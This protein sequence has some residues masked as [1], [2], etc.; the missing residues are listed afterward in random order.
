MTYWLLG[1]G[2][3]IILSG[4]VGAICSLNIQEYNIGVSN[5]TDPPMMEIN[6]QEQFEKINNENIEEYKTEKYENEISSVEQ[7]SSKVE[8]VDP[9]IEVLETIEVNIP[10]KS[11]ATDIAKILEK[12]G[13]I[14]DSKAFVDF[15]KE[16]K[17]TTKLKSGKIIFTK[18]S[19]YDEIL[20]ILAHD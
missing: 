1:F 19:S 2:C 3:G 14:E 15:I 11:M 13:V 18:N 9:S 20:E 16:K 17:K 6:N 12:A 5:V 4:I 10:S 7:E 8:R